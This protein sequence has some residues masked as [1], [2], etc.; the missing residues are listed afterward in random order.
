MHNGVEVCQRRRVALKPKR[1]SRPMDAPTPAADTAAAMPHALPAPRD[2]EPRARKGRYALYL[3]GGF[4]G[5]LG[6]ALEV[7]PAFASFT[8]NRVA[9]CCALIGAIILAVGRFS[10]DRIVRRF[11]K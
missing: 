10:P 5:A 6:I 1:S 8:P 3:L 4:F 2:E 11:G 7:V 9:R